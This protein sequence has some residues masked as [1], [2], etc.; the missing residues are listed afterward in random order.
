MAKGVLPL[1]CK[2]GPAPA[3]STIPSEVEAASDLWSARMALMDSTLWALRFCIYAN[4]ACPD[5]HVMCLSASIRE[6]G[7][8]RN[9]TKLTGLMCCPCCN[10]P[11]FETVKSVLV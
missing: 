6:S 4:S 3:N 10:N 7:V 1:E 2:D 9:P 8:S 11:Y 5:T